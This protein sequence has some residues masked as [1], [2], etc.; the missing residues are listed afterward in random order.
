[1]NGPTPPSAT[2]PTTAPSPSVAA[3]EGKP[4]VRRH[5]SLEEKAEHLALFA[6]SGL[7]QIEYCEEMGLSPATFSLWRRGSRVESPA[8]AAYDQT[9]AE[10]LV[11]EPTAGASAPLT[12]TPVVIHPGS[13]TRI[14]VAVGTDPLWL[15]SLLKKLTCA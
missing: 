10:V 2:I 13:G 6:E 11:T 4:R 15:A 12:A 8:E 7:S 5:W 9:F 14:E 1:M 3:S